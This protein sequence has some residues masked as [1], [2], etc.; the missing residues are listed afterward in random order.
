MSNL[1]AG[2]TQ[3]G[4]GSYPFYCADT[5]IQGWMFPGQNPHSLDQNVGLKRIQQ[6]GRGP[7]RSLS[8]VSGFSVNFLRE[9]F[10]FAA[11][12][13]LAKHVFTK[14]DAAIWQQTT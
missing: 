6:Q 9:I 3:L 4:Y 1:V 12:R 2:A 13:I 14:S 11:L 7:F 8:G 5:G 10:F